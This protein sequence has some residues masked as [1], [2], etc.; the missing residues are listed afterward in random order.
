M[1]KFAADE[2]FNNIILRGI[3]RRQS[4]VDIV[5]IQDTEVVGA[6]DDVVLAWAAAQDRIL[7][8]H[9]VNTLTGF[10]YDRVRQDLPMPGVFQ[11]DDSASIDTVIADILLIANVS[12]A[13]EWVD[14]VRYIPL[15]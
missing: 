7:L 10:A 15:Q 9:D 11:V 5:R 8:T 3:W 12:H 1:I 4:E 2:N 6:T 13:D 14:Q